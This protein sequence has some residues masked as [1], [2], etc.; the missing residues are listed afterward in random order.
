MITTHIGD[1][2]NEGLI[3]E[4]FGS[5]S[6]FA[7]LCEKYDLDGFM[8]GDVEVVYDDET[9]IHNFYQITE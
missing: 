6:E 3:E 4:I 2:R 5:V 8:Y 1:C 7:R 9:D